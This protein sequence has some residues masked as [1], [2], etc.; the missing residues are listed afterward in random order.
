M[1]GELKKLDSLLYFPL[2]LSTTL[3]RRLVFINYSHFCVKFHQP[4]AKHF[5]PTVPTSESTNHGRQVQLN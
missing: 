4:N 5:L 2:H 3:S 1:D